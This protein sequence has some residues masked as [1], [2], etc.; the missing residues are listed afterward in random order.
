M[1]NLPPG[2]GAAEDPGSRPLPLTLVTLGSLLLFASWLWPVTRL[3]WDQLDQA[4]FW[5]AN[6][7]L[8][9]GPGWQTFWAVANN[10][11]FD[12]VAGFAMLAVYLVSGQRDR[13]SSWDRMGAR[14]LVALL[15]A[16]LAVQFGKMLPI[17]RASATLLFPDS[18]RLSEL[19]PGISLK[20]SS[21]DSFPGDH[22]LV[23][24]I[25]VAYGW[26]YFARPYRYLALCLAVF[27][28]MPRLMSGAHWLSDELV[29]AVSIGALACAWVLFSRLGHWVDRRLVPKI[30]AWERRLVPSPIAGLLD[31]LDRR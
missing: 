17:E 20:D 6:A 13:R 24:F 10:R 8:E 25:A 15:I 31:R 2:G 30:V 3:Y 11:A 9:T 19:V 12:L 4:F 29:G 18:L 28:T 26:R 21:G 16:L 5:Y 7:S 14:L 23:L 1:S 22:G 27:F